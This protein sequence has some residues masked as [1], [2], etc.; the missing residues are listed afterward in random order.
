MWELFIEVENDF[1]GGLKD[2]GMILLFCKLDMGG[3]IRYG[4]E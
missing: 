3:L 4:K 1:Y 2:M